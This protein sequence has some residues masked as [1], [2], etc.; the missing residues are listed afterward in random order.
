MYQSFIPFYGRIPFRCMDTPYYLL[1]CPLMGIQLQQC[2]LHWVEICPCWH[3]SAVPGCHGMVPHQ[4]SEKPRGIWRWM[5][6]KLQWI[7]GQLPIYELF[8]PVH[9]LSLNEGNCTAMGGW[10][11]S[12]RGCLKQNQTLSTELG[13]CCRQETGGWKTGQKG[14][15]NKIGNDF[16]NNINW[17]LE[18]MWLR[19][20][21]L[22]QSRK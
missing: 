4:S 15:A 21:H 18:T 5:T 22:F 3:R 1:I 2:V 11:F 6:W 8:I 12:G 16:E 13:E 19:F 9:V 14:K 7:L 10:E 20:S 17:R